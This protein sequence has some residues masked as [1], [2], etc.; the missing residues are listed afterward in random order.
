[1]FFI[2]CHYVIIP[3]QFTTF[4][5]SW[6]AAKGD[7]LWQS[8]TR[9]SFSKVNGEGVKDL[10]LKEP[11]ILSIAPFY[12][13]IQQKPGF[14]TQYGIPMVW[15]WG[16]CVFA[17]IPILGFQALLSPPSGSAWDESLG[18]QGMPNATNRLLQRGGWGDVVETWKKQ[19][20]KTMRPSPKMMMWPK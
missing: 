6:L 11:V 9:S 19:W 8:T 7:Q 3:V 18:R 4:P 13:R 20:P 17:P 2:V 12:L 1:M 5:W 14:L 16:T 10:Y 15:F